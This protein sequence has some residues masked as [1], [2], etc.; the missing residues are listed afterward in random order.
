MLYNFVEFE[1]NG[2]INFECVLKAL[3]VAFDPS[4]KPPLTIAFCVCWIVTKKK[5][6]EE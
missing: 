6:E 2:W 1:E 3:N 4:K 5:E